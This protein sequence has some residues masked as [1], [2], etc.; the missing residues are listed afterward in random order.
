MRPV[1]KARQPP[2]PAATLVLLRDDPE[3][4]RVLLLRRHRRLAFHGG[5]W[6]F[7]GGRIEPADWGAGKPDPLAA[8]RRAAV[9]E[10]RE[11]AGLSLPPAACVPLSRWTTPRGLRRR[12]VTWFFA[13]RVAP[14]V[15]VRIDG[16][17]I[18]E[19]RW[20]SPAAALGARQAGQLALPPPTFVTLWE[21][22]GWGDAQTVLAHL[23]RRP[24]PRFRPRPC[25]AG[26]V[27]ILIF[28]GDA[29]CSGGPLA[30]P[31][32]RHRLVMCAEGWR[33]MSPAAPEAQPHRTHN[34]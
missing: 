19:S 32:P 14:A 12:F 21:L 17:E 13:A 18:V 25:T 10:T 9:R 29:A 2:V 23:V 20:L 1:E 3:G 7:P 33:Y 16:R 6:V 31:G 15:Q 30:G 11:E 34:L 27:P 5:A 22:S 26:G 8:A 24:L 28:R 4:L